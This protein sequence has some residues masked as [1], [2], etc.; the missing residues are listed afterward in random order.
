MA[1]RAEASGVH[2]NLIANIEMGAQERITFNHPKLIKTLEVSADECFDLISSQVLAEGFPAI[3]SPGS[4]RTFPS[5]SF[6]PGVILTPLLARTKPL[7][8]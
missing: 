7:N 3:P 1:Q 2:R 4:S 8:P 6:L 5:Q